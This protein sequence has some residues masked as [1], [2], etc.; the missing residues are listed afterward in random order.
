MNQ[1]DY[2]PYPPY[3]DQSSP[4]NTLQP[5]PPHEATFN[6]GF[7]TASYSPQRWPSGDVYRFSYFWA[8]QHSKYSL[9]LQQMSAT[10][11]LIIRLPPHR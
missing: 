9:Q 3:Y 10:S 11:A 7:S 1:V 4:Y 2:P 6:N 8:E 5:L